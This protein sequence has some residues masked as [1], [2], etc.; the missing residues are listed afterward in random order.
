MWFTVTEGL[1]VD[2]HCSGQRTVVFSATPFFLHG[3]HKYHNCFVSLRCFFLLRG[4][5]LPVHAFV[6]AFFLHWGLSF[7]AESNTS[8][9][10]QVKHCDALK[11]Q[12]HIDL[13]LEKTGEAPANTWLREVMLAKKEQTLRFPTW[14]RQ[15]GVS[16][17]NFTR[18]FSDIS[19]VFLVSTRHKWDAS[20]NL[21][22]IVNGAQ[23]TSL[24]IL[25]IE[26]S[27]H[28]QLHCWRLD[29]LPII[30]KESVRTVVYPAWMSR[31]PRSLAFGFGN[32][33]IAICLQRQ[34]GSTAAQ[35]ITAQM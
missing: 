31:R 11:F 35:D 15:C 24:S 5:L 21:K 1:P 14:L 28:L 19:R 23:K 34:C 32:V 26:H 3:S 16:S 29:A 4:Q 25:R 18:T 10:Q 9:V 22:K 7:G 27:E 13:V 8:S 30:S 6:V 17:W 12:F 2:L 20:G 33:K